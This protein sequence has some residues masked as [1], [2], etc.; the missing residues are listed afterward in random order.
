MIAPG[1]LYV[2]AVHAETMP[3]VATQ[4]QRYRLGREMAFKIMLDGI[5]IDT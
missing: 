2:A 5:C 4:V 3:H 1:A